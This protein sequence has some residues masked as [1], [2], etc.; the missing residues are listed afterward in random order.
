LNQAFINGMIQNKHYFVNSSDSTNLMFC[1]SIVDNLSQYSIQLIAYQ[2]PDTTTVGSTK[3]WIIPAG[4]TWTVP[5]SGVAVSG[6]Y[7][8]L[9]NKFPVSTK[10]LSTLNYRHNNTNI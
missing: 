2:F 9:Q 3:T 6:R 1:Y 7:H 8:L 10:Y 4:A 5:A